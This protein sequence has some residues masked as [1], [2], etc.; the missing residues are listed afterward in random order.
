MFAYMETRNEEGTKIRT[1][2]FALTTKDTLAERFTSKIDEWRVD[3]SEN[4]PLVEPYRYH[5][6]LE[7]ASPAVRNA[8][9]ERLSNALTE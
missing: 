7:F 8:R 3:R 2:V 4:D 1:H 5:C 6:N 9:V